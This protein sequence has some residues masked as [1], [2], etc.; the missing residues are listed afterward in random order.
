MAVD[1]AT[2]RRLFKDLLESV[3]GVPSQKPTAH[4]YT[5]K[6]MTEADCPQWI[7]IPT[8]AEHSFAY[9]TG[10]QTQRLWRLIL[11]YALEGSMPYGDIEKGLETFFEPLEDMF[12]L[13]LQAGSS[14]SQLIHALLVEDTGPG[15]IE[16]PPTSGRWWIGCEWLALVTIKRNVSVGSP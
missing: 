11:F 16:F 4:A 3:R 13:H 1:I 12:A 7:V 15:R 2:V 8:E 9:N 14:D 6:S 10:H 5:P